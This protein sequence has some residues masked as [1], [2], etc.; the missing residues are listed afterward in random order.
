MESRRTSRTVGSMKTKFSLLLLAATLA[1]AQTDVTFRTETEVMQV[2]ALVQDAATRRPV[3]G[4]D[5]NA[6]RLLIDGKERPISYF[7]VEGPERRPLALLICLNLAPE[8]ALR[9]LSPPAAASS[10]A[11]AVAGLQADDEAAVYA[12]PDWFVGSP[13]EMAP[14]SRDRAATAAALSRALALTGSA[15][16]EARRSRASTMAELVQRARQV[17]AARPASHVALVVISDG[18]NTLDMIEN[19]SRRDLAEQLQPGDISVSALTLDMR[20][21]YAAAAT[22]LNPI[23]K[24]FGMSVTGGAKQLSDETGG[25]AIAVDG[26]AHIGPALGQVVSAYTS[27][28]SIGFPVLGQEF[29]DGKRHKIEVKLRENVGGRYRINARRHF[30]G[31]P[32]PSR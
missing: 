17:A 31:E 10:F 22:A 23:G 30:R 1:A 9:Q 13:E 4:L 20:A 6:F 7:A 21:S 15:R 19:R 3:T 2:A 11:A 28:Y 8:G 25:I 29:A 18:M 12:V 27:R 5:R 24:L 16:E 26:P 14:L 32:A